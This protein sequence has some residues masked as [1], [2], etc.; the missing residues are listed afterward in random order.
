MLAE[1]PVDVP[2][3]SELLAVATFLRAAD[4]ELTMRIA[5]VTGVSSPWTP[6]EQAR[7]LRMLATGVEA[8]AIAQP[9]G[10]R[11]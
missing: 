4:G 10:D 1:I 8:E 2:E 9:A 7:A 3:G 11:A 6:A 5:N